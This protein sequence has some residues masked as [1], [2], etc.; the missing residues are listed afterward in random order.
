LLLVF[1]G[2]Q[3]QLAIVQEQLGDIQGKLDTAHELEGKWS[4]LVRDAAIRTEERRLELVVL[5]DATLAAVNAVSPVGANL[6]LE[7]SLCALPTRVVVVITHGIRH[8]AA[9][10]LA[11]AQLLSGLD[12]NKVEP[13]FL[14][15]SSWDDIDKMVGEF[16]EASF[17]FAFQIKPMS[18]N[19]QA[20]YEAIL[21]GLQL[22]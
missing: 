4:A 9:T 2:V 21:K 19:N 1:S 6:D 15:K 7:E 8:G 12:L 22:L 18:T 20:E 13:R 17:E 16:T 10:A 3:E 14:P 5:Q 11:A